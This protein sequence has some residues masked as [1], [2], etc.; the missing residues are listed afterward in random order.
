MAKT[1]WNTVIV[2]PVV[3]GGTW[4]VCAAPNAL[5]QIEGLLGVTIVIIIIIRTII[6]IV[7]QRSEFS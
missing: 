5:A 3:L 2:N 4:A 6:V 7:N 1:W